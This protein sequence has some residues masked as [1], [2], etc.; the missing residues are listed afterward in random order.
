M[1]SQR[2]SKVFSTTEINRLIRWIRIYENPLFFFLHSKAE[3]TFKEFDDIYF[4]RTG[5]TEEEFLKKLFEEG[6][7][8]CVLKYS[9][10]PS[11]NPNDID[12]SLPYPLYEHQFLLRLEDEE[13]RLKFKGY[14]ARQY[15]LRI[16]LTKTKTKTKTTTK[17]NTK[18]DTNP[19]NIYE[20]LHF[21]ILIIFCV[22][23]TYAGTSLYNHT[24][25]NY[26]SCTYFL[27]RPISFLCN[28]LIS[29]S[30]E[31][32]L[33]TIYFLVEYVAKFV[34][35]A[36]G[37]AVFNLFLL[38][39]LGWLLPTFLYTLLTPSIV[40]V[41]GKLGIENHKNIDKEEENKILDFVLSWLIY[42]KIIS[43]IYF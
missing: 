29:S 38:Q 22:L 23:V 5:V 21:C 30:L 11:G 32:I 41:L 27:G 2:F 14:I 33:Q 12:P 25:P 10:Y 24:L 7:R 19:K 8:E 26:D 16:P 9:D 15:G 1:S 39:M 13:K 17:K 4:D 28:E 6:K 34:G 35:V 40:S 37:C 20:D 3:R 31:I 42:V 36:F 43:M 18:L